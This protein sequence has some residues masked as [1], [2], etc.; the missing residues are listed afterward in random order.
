MDQTYM[1]R[2]RVFPL[3]A[4]MA[5]PMVISMLVN[6]MYNIVDSFFVAK[7][8]ENAMTAL[9]LVFPIQNLI[10]SAMIGF[11][12]GVNAAIAYFLGAK[13][14]ALAEKSAS[15]GMLLS[16]F[17]GIFLMLVCIL[18]MRPFL[19]LF[20]S[21]TE[22][23]GLGVQYSSIAFLFSVVIAWQL[24][25][26]KTFQ[27]VG[28]MTATM[29]CMMAG[30]IVNI[31]LDPVLIF[32]LGPFPQM[33]IRGAALAT[34]L[35][36]TISLL[37]YVWCYRFRPIP[38]KFRRSS[39]GLERT[40]CKR[41]Y[42][43]GIPGGL[44]MA[45]PSL[46]ISAL[47]VILGGFSQSYVFVLG[48][49]Y[50]LQTFL[51]LP[52]NGVVQGMRPIIG[53][54]YGAKEYQRVRKI[55]Y[56]AMMIVAGIMVVGTVLCLAFSAQLIGMFTTNSDTIAKGAEALRILCAG[57]IVS[58]VSVTATGALEGLGKGIPSLIISLCRYVVV[59]IPIAFA[60]SRLLGVVGVWHAFWVT[61]LMTSA[62]AYVYFLWI[63]KQM[64]REEE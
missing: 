33:G 29:V 19:Q 56:T 26:E 2:E 13:E 23:I 20:T 63:S 60:L 3:I 1:K 27:A 55:F 59:I 45:L 53:Y 62:F 30:F 11:G 54:N 37:F 18:S 4:K 32:G 6:S 17:H 46:L 44:N 24:V 39:M 64:T 42:L 43:V 47:N 52:A 25:F 7:I 16:T 31:V 10:N 61:E 12:I 51:Y 22:V 9:S 36:Q 41:L 50:K 57:F 40:I 38:V 21:D 58:S 48:I 5:L 34:G 8:S 49:Y 15:Q 28:R 35:G 14:Q